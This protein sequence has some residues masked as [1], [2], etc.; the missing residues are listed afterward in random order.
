MSAA[1]VSTASNCDAARPKLTLDLAS[2]LALKVVLLPPVDQGR[3][4][5]YGFVDD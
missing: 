3:D 1:S 4:W 2:H 5:G